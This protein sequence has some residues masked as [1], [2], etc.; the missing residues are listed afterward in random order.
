MRRIGGRLKEVLVGWREQHRKHQKP[1]ALFKT[2]LRD[3]RANW[4]VMLGATLIVALPVAILSNYGVDASGNTTASAYL[5]FVQLA[6]NVA[7]IYIVAKVMA[8]KPVTIRQAYYEGS[9]MLVRL[10][11]VSLLLVL[12]LLPLVLALVIVSAGVLAPGAALNGGE[13]GLLVLLALLIAVPSLILL[14][15]GLWALYVIF[16][17]PEGPIQAVTRSRR[18]SKGKV[19]VILG[20][21]LALLVFLVGILLIPTV[22]LVLLGSLTHWLVWSIILQVVITLTVLPLANLYLYRYYRELV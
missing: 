18:I 17:G 10:V 7:V 2:A 13:Q 19:M 16:E 11:L 3:Y 22:V 1:W 14:T 9:A 20:R 6:M 8:G 15:R 21:L 4:R 5:A 12:M